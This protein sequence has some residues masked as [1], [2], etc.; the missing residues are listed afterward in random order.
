MVRL[1]TATAS[2]HAKTP[3]H[4]TRRVLRQPL[5]GAAGLFVPPVIIVP[6]VVGVDCPCRHASSLGGS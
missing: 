4:V 6:T 1:E 3:T 2:V 5:P